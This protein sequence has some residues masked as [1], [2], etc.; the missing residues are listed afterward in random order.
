MLYITTDKKQDNMTN[1]CQR[2]INNIPNLCNG[3]H[4]E[5]Y[6]KQM[7]LHLWQGLDVTH[8]AEAYIKSH[9]IALESHQ[10]QVK[11]I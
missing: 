5:S 6:N 4:Q 11:R 1:T 9:Q 10:M 3:Y 8:P 2:A 7:Q